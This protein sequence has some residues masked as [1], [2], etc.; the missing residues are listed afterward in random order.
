[1]IMTNLKAGHLSNRSRIVAR[2]NPISGAVALAVGSISVAVS[3][4]FAAEYKEELVVTAS[5]RDAMIQDVPINIS[6]ISGGQIEEARIDNAADLARIIP[7]LVIVDQGPRN[8]SPAIIRGLNTDNLRPSESETNFN[9]GTVATYFGE[10]PVYIDLK[11]IDLE[12]IEILRGPQGTLYGANSLAGNIRY[13]PN[14]P[15]TDTFELN[16]HG[17]VYGISESDSTSIDGDLILNVPIADKFGLR[18]V[19]GYEH[20]QGFIDYDFLVQEVGV[21]DPEPDFTN[22]AEIAANLKQRKDVN[23][24]KTTTVRLSG[25]WEISDAVEL[26]VG[27]N[28]QDQ[29]IGGRQANTTESLAEVPNLDPVGDYVSGYRVLEPIDRKNQIF[30]ADLIADIGFAELTWATG[31]TKYEEDGNRDQTDLLLGFGYPYS[32]F[33]SFSAYTRD[34]A[35]TD[36]TTS[37]LRL[38][39]TSDG[40]LSWIGGVFYDDWEQDI[41]SAERTPFLGDELNINL[42]EDVEFL[43]V[44]NQ[45]VNEWAVFGEIGF[46]ITES[47]NVLIGGRYFENE[48]EVKQAFATPIFDICH[49]ATDPDNHPFFHPVNPP[50]CV[51]GEPGGVPDGQPVVDYLSV[52][53]PFKGTTSDSIFKFNTSYD[54]TDSA[55][56]YITIAEGYRPGGVNLVPP[57]GPG[58]V[59]NNTVCGTPGE[60]TYDADKTLNYEIGAKTTW[61]GGALVANAALFYIDWTDI[62]VAG[63]SSGG[64]VP[65]TVNGDDAES[66]GVELEMAASFAEYWQLT[67]GYAYANAELTGP[68]PGITP[69]AGDGDRLPGSPE[70]QGSIFLIYDRAFGSLGFNARYGI[71][72][73]SDVFTKIGMG[74]DCCRDDG[75]VLNGFALHYLSVGLYGEQWEATLFADNLF[76]RYAETGVRL[77]KSFLG[78]SGGTENF[79]QRRYFKYMATPRAIGLDIRYK[80][81]D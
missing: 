40:R 24:L 27:Y 66:K 45:K 2:L 76:D 6:A 12:R 72:A 30:S 49:D 52:G 32:D 61:F 36:R 68:A 63:L 37:E 44:S 65:I 70:H 67:A 19:L 69:G 74:S 50:T 26:T 29:K 71:T 47:W 28:L 73:Q 34:T 56:G 48:D 33:P 77:D 79:T 31:H 10:I 14:K 13:I 9:G 22:A 53:P 38:V 54:F 21:S 7:G 42:T 11:P 55:L 23:D 60:L 16:A 15:N 57:C 62:Q 64:F 80:F 41:V 17:K 39:S 3:P 58:D 35:T 4:S 43:Q 75:E 5:R 20:R 51:S 46:D 25:L 1:M 8:G 78:S 81:G 18:G 59:A